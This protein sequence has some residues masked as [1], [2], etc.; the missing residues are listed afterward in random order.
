MQLT[1]IG[2]IALILLLAVGL[3]AAYYFWPKN[4]ETAATELN[5]TAPEGGPS[6]ESVASDD[7]A[8]SDNS[9]AS[10][11]KTASSEATSS[12]SSEAAD[13]GGGSF[14]YT[15]PAPVGG[16]TK[17]VV[18]LGAS[19]FN[20]FIVNI[21]K[22]KNWKLESAEFGNSMVIEN[23][24]TDYD[25]RMGLK[26]YIANMIDH[27]VSGKNIH[28]VVSS[29][30]M[31]EAS[32]TKIIRV[33]KE[34]GYMVNTVTPEQ[35]GTLALKCVLPADY[36]NNAYVVDIGS[37]NT[38]ISWINGGS[39]TALEAPGSKYYEKNT[40][41]TDVYEQVKAK[42]K[43]IPSS[44]REVCFIIGGVPFELAKEVRK[45]KERYTVLNAPDAYK[46]T[47]AK[48]KAGVNIYKG[49]VDATG[50]KTFV[51]DWDANFTIGFLL[52]LK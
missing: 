37:G 11:D 8:A 14:S 20:S 21:D 30:A 35:E 45:G 17:G 9:V 48:T 39:V 50:T 12:A 51:F 22:S 24:A 47:K 29:G 15:S 5:T 40:A 2:K 43:Q 33:L 41:D 31:K 3:G 10:D 34:M 23:M 25:V 27:G 4:G 46:S 36:Q 6:A 49:I 26:R 38:K 28:F 7:N 42:A 32:T 13:T 16:I 18:E 44:K 52:G 1:G 19:G